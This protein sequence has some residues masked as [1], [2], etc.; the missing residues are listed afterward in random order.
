MIFAYHC[1][2]AQIDNFNQRNLFPFFEGGI[3][4][5]SFKKAR[6][7]LENRGKDLVRIGYFLGRKLKF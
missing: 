1:E 3:K 2:C 4:V 5:G 6:D 7:L